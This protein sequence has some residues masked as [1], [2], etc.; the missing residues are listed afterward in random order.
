MALTRPT[1]SRRPSA[2]SLELSAATGGRRT[3]RRV[4]PG[5]QPWLETDALAEVPDRGVTSSGGQF[6]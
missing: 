5:G 6:T 1:A 4:R 3:A 2:D